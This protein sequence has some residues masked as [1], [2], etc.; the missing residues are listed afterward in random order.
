MINPTDKI[1]FDYYAQKGRV[2]FAPMEIDDAYDITH[3]LYRGRTIGQVSD[4]VQKILDVPNIQFLGMACKGSVQRSIEVASV[5][6]NFVPDEDLND[7]ESEAR[8]NNQLQSPRMRKLVDDLLELQDAADELVQGDEDMSGIFAGTGNQ[9]KSGFNDDLRHRIM[10]GTPNIR[11]ILKSYGALKELIGKAKRTKIFPSQTVIKDVKLGDDLSKLLTDELVLLALPELQHL[12]NLKFVNKELLQYHLEEEKPTGK[13]AVAIYVDTS[14][15]MRYSGV[16]ID[17]VGISRY[18]ASA[19]VCLAIIAELETQGRE[20]EVFGF[21][22]EVWSFGTSKN[23]NEA[24]IV[25]W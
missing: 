1:I 5:I 10:K 4:K 16:E 18:T 12:A 11:N 7:P 17:G 8:L 2:D 13:G 22:E 6:S 20:Y 21:N 23:S 19:G 25:H 24:C 14:E 3:Y 9:T 15:S